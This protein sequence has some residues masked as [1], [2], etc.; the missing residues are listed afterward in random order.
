MASGETATITFFLQDALPPGAVPLGLYLT[1]YDP[2]S[3]SSIYF[4]SR[5][6]I[7]GGGQ[8]PEPA[9][10][11]LMGLGLTGVAVFRR[12]FRRV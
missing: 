9:T 3:Q 8:V 7:G 6:T 5:L 2:D 12:R 11:L 4:W 1:Q 10:M